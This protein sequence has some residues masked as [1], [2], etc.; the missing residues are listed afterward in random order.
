MT[1]TIHRHISVLVVI[2]IPMFADVIGSGRV[3]DR[4]DENFHQVVVVG[5][6]FLSNDN[7]RE[8]FQTERQ[9]NE[10][11]VATAFPNA[12]AAASVIS[13][14]G[15]TDMEYDEW[16]HQFEALRSRDPLRM[17]E[18]ISIGNETVIRGVDNGRVSRTVIG[19]GSDPT[20]FDSAGRRCEIL[21]IYFYRLPRPL[22]PDGGNPLT[23]SVY[24]R[25]A[26]LPNES[27][28]K[29]IVHELQR[30]LRHSS[31]SVNISVD[32]WF[33]ESARFPVQF[34]FEIDPKPPTL[35]EYRTR[36]QMFC[37]GSESAVVCHRFPSQ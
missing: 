9:A 35:G 31:I 7:L 2:F 37:Q 18:L 36:A 27:E 26:P 34:P 20:F 28:A 4:R 14:K 13:G 12:D 22:Q 6:K 25:V 30:R 10:N 16:K 24:V 17:K 5:E 19:S 33:I 11:F 29:L 1:A 32:S 15:H 8:L 21:E 23:V 3:V